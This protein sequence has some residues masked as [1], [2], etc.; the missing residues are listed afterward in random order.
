MKYI[1]AYDLGT[2]GIKSSLFDENGRSI[3]SSFRECVT[4]FPNSDFRVQKPSDWWELLKVTTKELLEKV[5]VD[6]ND[7]LG[8]GCSGHSLG[9]VP[10]S[11]DGELLQEFVPIWTDARA[12]KEEIEV[13]KVIDEKSWYLKTGNGFPAK[14]YAAFK[15]L[16]YKNNM[17]EMYENT[18]VF[19]G[20]K[21]YLNYKLTD[22][23]GTD[24]SYA[25]GSGVYDLIKCD[26][27]A[28]Y[29][30]KFG[31]RATDFPK[32]Y[33]ASDVLGTIKKEVA[34]E[35]G[36]SETTKVVAGG[37]DNACMSAGAGCVAN[38]SAYTS[39]GTSAWIAVT[40][41]KP[42]VNEKTRPYVF[43]HLIKGMYASAESIFSAGNT[44][45]WVRDNIFTDF[46]EIQ[47]AGGK[48]AY[49]QMDEL[50]KGSPIGANGLILAP[51]LAGGNSLDKCVDVR[52]SFVGLD[53]G[54]TRGDIA[55]ATLEGICLNLRMALEE[56]KKDVEITGTML[57]VGG[58]AK[59]EFWKKLFADIYDL[60]I[61]ESEVGENAGS[62]GACA[63]AAIGAGLWN[64]YSKLEQIN[65]P[66]SLV[67]KEKQN[68]EKYD[69]LRVIFAKVCD[70][71]SDIAIL[72]KS[73][74][75]I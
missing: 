67:K 11:N 16:W 38:G 48:N 60:D 9:V 35:L 6:K 8:V 22:V 40:S 54:H 3:A 42:I 7:I 10:I 39:L 25:S 53:L 74:E 19:I 1:I 2:G 34:E 15:I 55:R 30:E 13:F 26:Y 68:V 56:L 21:D 41:D 37:V 66:I 23:L 29:I 62:L 14:L 70:I 5:C 45:R 33:N 46:V 36:L 27:D 57:I 47:K 43:G 24:Y 73:I 12:E 31:L 71:Q 18:K 44:F 64:D 72:R 50:A 28:N 51:Q 32:L 61:T 59:S 17:T 4:Y 52:G 63:C 75:N 65:K 69:A 58:G 49:G 20:T